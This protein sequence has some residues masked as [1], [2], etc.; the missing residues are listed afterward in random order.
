VTQL[1]FNYLQLWG[2][3]EDGDYPYTSGTT[4]VAGDCS[5]DPAKIRVTLSGYDTLPAN[6]HDA[7]MTHIAEV[8][9]C[10]HFPQFLIFNCRGY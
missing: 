2:H 6:N 9:F 10:L 5:H 8:H 7:V 3:M 1:A 4:S